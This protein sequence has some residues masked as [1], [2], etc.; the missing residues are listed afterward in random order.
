[1][2]ISFTQNLVVFH[3]LVV[4]WIV[5]SYLNLLTLGGFI[6]SGNDVQTGGFGLLEHL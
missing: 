3:Q 5:L 6:L 4:F 2:E 1:M